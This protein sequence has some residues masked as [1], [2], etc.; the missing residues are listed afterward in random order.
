MIGLFLLPG[1]TKG[2][3]NK[4]PNVIVI[5]VDDLGY[6]ELGCQ[7]NHQIPTPNIDSIAANGV[8]FTQ[9][10]VTSPVCSTSRAGLLTGRHQERFGYTT[11]LIGAANDEPNAGL[12]LQEKTIANYLSDSGFFFLC[13]FCNHAFTV[14]FT[15]RTRVRL[16]AWRQQIC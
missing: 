3:Q 1:I 16:V 11:N 12:P 10:Y 13:C 7:G 15:I 9:G 4:L 2:Q 8:R 6:G 14:Q 5:L